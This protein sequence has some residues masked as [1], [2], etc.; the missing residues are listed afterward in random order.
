MLYAMIFKG[1]KKIYA[2]YGLKQ[3]P[4]AWFSKL[5]Q[6]IKANGLQKHLISLHLYTMQL[7]IIFLLFMLKIFIVTKNDIHHI[8]KVEKKP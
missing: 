5:Y 3:S 4:K 2:S 8:S 6:V 7:H 1:E